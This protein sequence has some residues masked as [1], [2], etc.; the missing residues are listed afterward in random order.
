M[1]SKVLTAT[2]IEAMEP[3]STLRDSAGLYLRKSAEGNTS[4]LFRYMLAGRA[5]M[6]GLGPYPEISIARARDLAGEW[7]AKLKLPTPVDPL[8]ER[9]RTLDAMRVNAEN[10]FGKACE[11]WL[12]FNRE[13]WSEGYA[14]DVTNLMRKN[15]APIW[16]R[17]VAEID[18]RALIDLLEPLWQRV[19]VTA[20]RVRQNVEGVLDR[21]VSKGWRP[22]GLNPARWD[23]HLENLLLSIKHSDTTHIESMPID[24]VPAFVAKLRAVD[25]VAARAV[26]FLLLTCVRSHDVRGA[27]WSDVDLDNGLWNIP[28]LSK[29][30][31]P[32]IVPLTAR[33]LEIL[34][35]LPRVSEYI[36]ASAKF[37]SEP[38][39]ERAFNNAMDGLTTCKPHGLRAAFKTWSVER[40]RFP[41]ATVEKCMGHVVRDKV[42]R[43]YNRAEMVAKRRKVMDAWSSFC[44]RPAASADVLPLR[45]KSNV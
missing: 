44:E 20:S 27:K 14:R 40:A 26:E 41:E 43:A 17:P 16:N 24:D 30:G 6:A 29:V 5:R 35:G 38:I 7:R 10:T 3:A 32:F 12:T 37:P 9:Q 2:R 36:F 1:K 8:D 31:V 13:Q 15:C 18:D 39:G 11:S 21:A 25:H 42:V 28:E 4:W 19:R 33:A 23:G 22:A 34:R 45:A